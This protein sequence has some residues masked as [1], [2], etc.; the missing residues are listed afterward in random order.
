[1][2]KAMRPSPN[3]MISLAGRR[4]KSGKVAIPEQWKAIIIELNEYVAAGA[5]KNKQ[6]ILCMGMELIEGDQAVLCRRNA[7]HDKEFCERHN[8]RSKK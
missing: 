6:A 7:E 4:R 2:S 5:G 8:G 3:Q 1:M